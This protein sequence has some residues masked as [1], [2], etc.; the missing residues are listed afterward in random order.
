MSDEQ[1][2]QN[3]DE[4][5]KQKGQHTWDVEN[6][7]GKHKIIIG[8]TEGGACLNR[9]TAN[10]NR[11]TRRLTHSSCNY[12]WQ[13]FRRALDGKSG[14]DQED[15]M[16]YNWPAYEDILRFVASGVKSNG[17][18][19]RQL[20]LPARTRQ[21]AQLA[22]IPSESN[23]AWDISEE[24]DN[25]Q[26]SCNKPYWHESHH[27]IPNGE[28]QA[29][30]AEAAEGESLAEEYVKLIRGGLLDEKYNLNHTINMI[31][32][33]MPNQVAYALGL[34]RHRASADTK[35]HTAYSH[36]AGA[37]LDKIIKPI[38]KQTQEHLEPDY[39]CCKDQLENL[40]D[41][42]RATII[43]AGRDMKDTNAQEDNALDDLTG[44]CFNWDFRDKTRQDIT[45]KP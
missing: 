34:P 8:E 24:G 45:D 12:R 10:R 35:S 2:T 29:A 14:E 20:S 3:Q 40:S 43:K 19:W 31:I 7:P 39:A 30:I 16:L 32:L 4:Q 21:G 18:R 5:D 26:T 13:A 33:P 15:K 11:M 1:N 22:K 42:L 38:Q 41:R 23:K 44:D 9:H 37:E 6:L 28:L 17:T 36:K 27:I 25:F